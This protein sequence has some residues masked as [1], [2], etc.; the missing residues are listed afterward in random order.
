MSASPRA[1]PGSGPAGQ[2]P[3]AAAQ[4]TA[5]QPT[6]ALDR[7]RRAEQASTRVQNFVGGEWLDAV[8]G[9]VMPVTNPA[10]GQVIAQAPRGA[11]ADV[12]R[13][14]AVATR[15][16]PG[17]LETTPKERADMLLRL[18]DAMGG[19]A[20]ELVATES[21]NVGKPRSVGE[22]EIPFTADNL[23]FFAGAARVMAKLG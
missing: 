19:H 11:R 12:D 23:R 8:D 15:A 6:A 5:A 18:A 17:W 1:T 20:A 22:P 21:V 9:A 14:V 4:T 16:L 3:D 10:T 2:H 13:A 7:Q